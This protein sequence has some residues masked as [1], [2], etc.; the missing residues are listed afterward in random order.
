MCR[1]PVFALRNSRLIPEYTLER[2]YHVLAWS[3]KVSSRKLGT[4]RGQY[5]ILCVPLLKG[6]FAKRIWALWRFKQDIEIRPLGAEVVFS[7][8]S[9][10]TCPRLYLMVHIPAMTLKAI[11]CHHYMPSGVAN[12]L[13]VVVSFFFGHSYLFLC[14]HQQPAQS[15]LA[16]HIQLAGGS[17][18]LVEHR[19][20]WK[21]LREAY[22]LK[23]HW[24]AE[25]YVCHLCNAK[26][27]KNTCRWSRI[28]V[29][30]FNQICLEP[31]SPW[32]C[33]LRLC[34]FQPQ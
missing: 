30:Y 26:S 10:P 15:S 11:H 25:T 13:Q 31:L 12:Q 4:P 19:G 16:C 22:G 24:S 9:S 6:Q 34:V 7:S 23:A 33:F 27:A 28:L 14:Q 21:W 29:L 2:V 3:F 17:A 1:F 32:I 5:I 8:P 18:C 20:D